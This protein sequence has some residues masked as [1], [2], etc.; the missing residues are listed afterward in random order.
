MMRNDYVAATKKY[1]L[2][3]LVSVELPLSKCAP[4]ITYNPFSFEGN[5]LSREQQMLMFVSGPEREKFV[6]IM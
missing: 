5:V 2:N 3:S 6:F 1:K 4:P